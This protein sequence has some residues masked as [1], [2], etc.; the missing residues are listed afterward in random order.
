MATKV[1]LKFPPRSQAG[2]R[3]AQNPR[4]VSK[5]TR[6]RGG[7][8]GR[9]RS[10]R[11]RG[12][13][14]GRGRGRGRGDRQGQG[15]R[16]VFNDVDVTNWRRTFSGEEFSQMGAQGRAYVRDRRM[17]GG[18]REGQEG[19]DRGGRNPGGDEHR[20]IEQATVDDAASQ[21]QRLVPYTGGA[22]NA[23][24]SEAHRAAQGRGAQA[25][26]GF[27]RGMYGRGGHT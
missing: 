4:R 25:G 22:S 6:G 3:K 23:N 13:R 9:G 5:A 17:A 12:G 16:I 11:G 24:T 7:R 27:G 20:Q 26:R 10:G 21:E 8:G 1:A 19:L 2:K 15:G 18:G 14:D